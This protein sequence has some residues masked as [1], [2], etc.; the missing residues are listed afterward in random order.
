MW[1]QKGQE[2]TIVKRALD[3]YGQR[4]ME[5]PNVIGLGLGRARK[6]KNDSE[7]Y[8]VKVYVSKK[9]SIFQRHVPSNLRL[10]LSTDPRHFISVPTEIEEVGQ[11]ELET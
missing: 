4:L 11:I 9:P 1:G 7:L 3:E 5:Y 10:K 8:V 2:E 6:N